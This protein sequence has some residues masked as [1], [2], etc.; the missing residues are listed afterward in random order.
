MFDDSERQAFPDK[1]KAF[2]ARLR[3]VYR[4]DTALVFQLTNASARTE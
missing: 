2:A 4:D 3:L 1:T